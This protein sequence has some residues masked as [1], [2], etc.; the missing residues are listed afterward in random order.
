[1]YLIHITSEEHWGQIQQEKALLPKSEL[2]MSRWQA[3]VAEFQGIDIPQYLVGIP[4]EGVPRWQEYGLLEHV[5][6]YA[7][8]DIALRITVPGNRGFVREH[9]YLSPM[10]LTEEYGLDLIGLMKQGTIKF[11]DKRLKKARNAYF[12]SSIPLREFHGQFILPEVWIPEKTDISQ[13]SRVTIDE[14]LG[15]IDKHGM[16]LE[17]H[18]AVQ[19]S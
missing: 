15:N 8:G 12:A 7:K 17:D 6:S 10:R 16:L 19:I 13:I 14:V 11:K 4:E 1:M 5:I 3:F 2:S 18:G 9:V